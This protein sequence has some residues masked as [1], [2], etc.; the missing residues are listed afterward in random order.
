[1]IDDKELVKLIFGLKIKYLRNQKRLSY[2]ELSDTSG[3]GLSYLHEIEKGKKYPKADKIM[4]LAEVL[5]VEYD[6]LVSLKS[7]RTLQPILNL[8][9]SDFF[10]VFP[11]DNFGLDRDKLIELFLF[12]PERLNAFVST[13]E[14]I[15]RS[16][17]I[18]EEDFYL[19]A[20]SSYQNINNNYF[21]NL[22]DAVRQ[23]KTKFK[24]T[25][26]SIL[27]K[28]KL[29]K[30]L[31]QLFGFKVN[32]K[33]LKQHKNLSEIRSYLDAKKGILFLN[34]DLTNAQICFLLAR[35]IAFEYLALTE[36]HYE[37]RI[38]KIDNYEKLL[39]NFK[40][41]YFA[42][43]LLIDEE[44]I[45]KDLSNLFNK[46]KWEPNALLNLIKKYNST[47]EMF[48][49]RLTNILPTH[50]KIRDLFF[51]RLHSS[52]DLKVFSIT[53]ELHLN[54]L[55]APYTNYSDE[56]YCRRW[57]SIEVLKKLRVMKAT[58]AL[59]AD[60]QISDYH[61][62][63]NKYLLWSVAKKSHRNTKEGTSVNLG[64]KIDAHLQNTIQFLKDDKLITKKVHT[65]CQRCSIEDC[66]Q[67][68][69]NPEIIE[70]ETELMDIENK[71]NEL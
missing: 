34:D 42:G 11:M 19:T 38:I 70:K 27:K 13:I 26:K 4:K 67:R 48:F 65:T 41:S 66:L 6:E 39:N 57:V 49:Q 47:P 10:K 68:A 15:I 12:A 51:L 14:K 53:K 35:E 54:R 16:H 5:G 37:T 36:R 8:I 20:L 1:M 21:K 17:H 60:G 59:V 18:K 28:E 31:Y 33:A 50:F 22:E 69:A 24:I 7:N 55:H 61:N 52:S 3:I 32:T 40:A 62:S 29:E 71:L 45:I 44:G 56:K 23:F 58:D 46:P 64:L 43:A 9:K 25:R 63:E 30:I 2:K